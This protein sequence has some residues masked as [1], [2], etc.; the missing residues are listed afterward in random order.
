M[1]QDVHFRLDG[2]TLYISGTGIVE[3]SELDNSVFNSEDFT[4]EQLGNIVVEEGI[5]AIGEGAFAFCE[6]LEE[7]TFGT[8]LKEIGDN[9]ESIF[10][11]CGSLKIIKAPESTR[12][13]FEG[14]GYDLSKFEWY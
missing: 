7:V 1:V 11:D 3:S 2:D 5:V 10:Y 9:S 13:V 12:K 4:R 6:N 8:G 14:A